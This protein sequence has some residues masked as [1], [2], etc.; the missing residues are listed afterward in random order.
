MKIHF[1]TYGTSAFNDTLDRIKNEAKISKF[2]NTINIYK[3]NN[4]EKEFK[5]KYKDILSIRTGAGCYI[6]KLQVIKQKLDSINENDII[7]YLDAGSSINK[8]GKD[9]FNEYI[10]K[11]SESE[12]GFLVFPAGKGKYIYTNELLDY[13][14]NVYNLNVDN[15]TNFYIGGHLIIKKNKNTKDIINSYFKL[16]EY[17][18]YLITDKYNKN[19]H[20]DFKFFRHD[21]SIISLLLNV[22][23]CINTN[24]PHYF[25]D[26]YQA[27]KNKDYKKYPFLATRLRYSCNL[28]NNKKQQKLLL[29]KKLYK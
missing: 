29:M 23:G 11:I 9:K 3:P 5:E 8:L 1:I 28:I 21:M 18:K 7:V 2:F 4:L 24:D 16:L 6:W 15:N 19:Q 13:F 17:D 20:Q 26:K 22:H 25:G 12:Y 27:F 10:N 14:E